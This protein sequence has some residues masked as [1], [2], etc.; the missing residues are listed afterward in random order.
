MADGKRRILVF[1]TTLRDGE[2]APGNG[3]R[4]A[5]KLEMAKQIELL[6]ADVIEAGFA[7]S[8]RDDFQSVKEIAETLKESTVCCL[9]RCRKEDIDAA[10]AALEN[11]NRRPRLHLFVSTSPLH[12]RYKLRLGE[13]EVLRLIGESVAYARESFEDIQFSCEDATRTEREFLVRAMRRAIDAGAT[14]INLP[15]TVGYSYPEEISD[16]FRFAIDAIGD[17]A[18]SVSAHCHNDLGLAVANTL[19]AITAGATQIEVTVNGIGERAGNAA[20]EETA[21]ALRVRS[22]RYDAITGIRPALIYPTSQM[23]SSITGVKLSPT[24]PL[25]GKNAFRHESGI[26]QHGVLANR[27]TYEIISPESIGIIRDDMVLGKHSGKHALRDCLRNM[28]VIIDESS[29][30]A[31]FEQFKK[32]AEKKKQVTHKDLTYLIARAKGCTRVAPRFALVNYGITTIGGNAMAN[33][34]LRVGGEE[35]VGASEGA[36]PIDAAFQAVNRIIGRDIKLDDWSVTA[37]SEGKDAVGLAA[38]R[39]S[40]GAFEATG[41]GL[42]TDTVEASIKAY[43]DGCNKLYEIMGE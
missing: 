10:R 32:I 25:V 12:M 38:L 20:L 16:L 9:A 13:D 2:Q 7:A 4:V 17:G 23:L 35:K 26:H 31:L 5:E 6:G 27:Q 22:D 3:M 30:D 28:N 11:A 41:R 39:L 14:T 37:L 21:M 40:Y 8:S 19:A 24:K 43:V 29:F 36:G 33:I 18:I 1:D 34:A 15:D 42:S